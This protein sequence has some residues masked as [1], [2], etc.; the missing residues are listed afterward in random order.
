MTEESFTEKIKSLRKAGGVP[1]FVDELIAR[2]PELQPALREHIDEYDEILPSFF[3]GSDVTDFVV[4]HERSPEVLQRLLDTVEQG[5]AEGDAMTRN[6]I[7]VSFFEELWQAGDDLDRMKR[8]MGP[9]CLE[10]LSTF[11][12]DR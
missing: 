4:Q 2:V 3:V 11:S 9:Q 7:A 10:M 5:L 12:A 8:F 6:L 1:A